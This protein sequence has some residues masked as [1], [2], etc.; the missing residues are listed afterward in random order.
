MTF[1]GAVLFATDAIAQTVM[2]SGG[3]YHE[4]KRFSGD[5]VMNVLDSDVS[6]LHVGVGTLVAPRC[7][8]ALEIGIS[9]TS[10]KTTSS[11]VVFQGQPV[12]IETE[13][14]N[15]LSTWSALA[16]LRG[17]AAGRLQLTYVGGLTFAHFRREIMPASL[18]PILQPAPPPTTSVTIDHVPAATAGLDAAI[19]AVNHL[20][21]VIFVRAYA[22]RLS[23]DLGGFVVRP[24]VAALVTF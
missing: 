11:S 9:G 20:A 7:S 2:I 8:V 5:P 15:R 1:V 6:G 17:P 18:A 14:V 10:N 23:S 12:S 22:L 16:G 4:S 3:Y 24:G 19:A 13:Y 21:I